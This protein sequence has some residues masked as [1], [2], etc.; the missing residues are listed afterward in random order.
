[1]LLCRLEEHVYS[2]DA[3]ERQFN[4]PLD[5]FCVELSHRGIGAGA[6]ITPA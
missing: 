2:V 1:M 5:S 3:S 6:P 4:E